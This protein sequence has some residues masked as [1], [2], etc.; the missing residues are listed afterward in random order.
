M[1][2]ELPAK[3]LGATPPTSELLTRGVGAEGVPLDRDRAETGHDPHHVAGDEIALVR[4][5]TADGGG[6]GDLDAPA[7]AFLHRAGEVRAEVAVPDR[8]VAEP[9][10]CPGELVDDQAVHVGLAQP[11]AGDQGVPAA[12]EGAV[13][14]DDGLA[15]ISRLRPPV[16]HDR[17][18]HLRQRCDGLDRLRTAPDRELDPVPT[19]RGIRVQEG[20]PQR[21]GAGVIRVRDGVGGG[22]EGK[23]R[24]KQDED[25]RVPG[26]SSKSHFSL[27]TGSR[28]CLNA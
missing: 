16:D 22:R 26:A 20:L 9:D 28:G 10:P 24:Q 13:D 7:A 19:R 14:L 4:A 11:E 12:R 2:M 5:G 17:P 6:S 3:T 23:S 8:P 15:G 25:A 18:G 27:R 1:P 21:A